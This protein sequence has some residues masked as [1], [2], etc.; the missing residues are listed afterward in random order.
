MRRNI[1]YDDA[2]MDLMLDFLTDEAAGWRT[3]LPDQARKFS[4]IPHG[5]T[6][7][8]RSV[9]VDDRSG[10]MGVPPVVGD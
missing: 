10:I 1:K 6:S 7:L 5:D 2:N 3:V 8:N 4:A 9:S